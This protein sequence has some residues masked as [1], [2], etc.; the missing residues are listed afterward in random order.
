MYFEFPPVGSKPSVSSTFLFTFQPINF[1]LIKEVSSKEIKHSLRQKT[2]VPTPAP[3]PPPS[4]TH[5]VSN[6]RCFLCLIGVL[7]RNPICQAFKFSATETKD[8]RRRAR[9]CFTWSGESQEGNGKGPGAPGE[10][11]G[12]WL[13]WLTPQPQLKP[14]KSSMLHPPVGARLRM[15]S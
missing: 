12:L 6:H 13:P 4:F 7:K 15:P 10:E 14:F 11:Q 3:P 9:P 5:F 1:I 2:A 8:N